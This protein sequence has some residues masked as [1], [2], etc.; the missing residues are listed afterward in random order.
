MTDL[1]LS[2]LDRMGTPA[3]RIGDSKG[4]L[5]NLSGLCV[6]LCDI[7]KGLLLQPGVELPWEGTEQQPRRVGP[8]VPDH[9]QA[10][11][12]GLLPMAAR[13]HP[14]ARGIQGK[15]IQRI[16][17]NEKLLTLS[18]PV[19]LFWRRDP[20][21]A[22]ADGKMRR[23]ETAPSVK[24][25]DARRRNCSRK[26]KIVVLDV[27][28]PTNSRR[29]YDVWHHQHQFQRSEDLR[30]QSR[31][32]KANYL[33]HCAAGGQREALKSRRNAVPIESSRR[34]PQS[35]GEAGKPIDLCLR[36]QLLLRRQDRVVGV[37][38]GGTA[39]LRVRAACANLRRP[40]NTSPLTRAGIAFPP[41]RWRS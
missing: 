10:A 21:T 26:Q 35:E 20:A 23:L 36:I 14:H 15:N 29:P 37:W 22:Q 32:T 25:L 8:A 31:W 27:R 2:M 16:C 13:H 12:W 6:R 4:K 28:T 3:E 9:P 1:F 40:V 24:N 7:E 34:R 39:R 11:P 41:K 5:A 30:R 18:P 33:V 17:K 19:H 38:R